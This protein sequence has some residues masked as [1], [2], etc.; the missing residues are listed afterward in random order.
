MSFGIGAII[1]A[2]LGGA[3]FIAIIHGMCSNSVW[4]EGEKGA[5]QTVEWK[6]KVYR[7]IPLED[8][9]NAD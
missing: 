6:G 3:I 7:L 1:A 2:F 4:V 5:V 8:K 9:Q